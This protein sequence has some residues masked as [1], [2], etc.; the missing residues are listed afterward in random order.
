VL[1]APKESRF[2]DRRLMKIRLLAP[3]VALGFCMVSAR[4][5]FTNGQAATYVLGQ[6]SLTTSDSNPTSLHYWGA[7]DVAI[8]A[9]TGKAFVIDI[10]AS[11]ILRYSNVDTLAMGGAPE[12]VLGQ[13]NLDV[14]S[15]GTSASQLNNPGGLALDSS[16]RLWVA[17][18]GNNRVLRFDNASMKPNG[19]NAD[20]VLGQNDFVNVAP[21]STQS[22][23]SSPAAV[24]VDNTGTLWIADTQNNRVLRFANAATKANGA[25]ADGVLGQPNFTSNAITIPAT[26]SS[27]NQP[28]GLCADSSGHLWVA[29]TNDARVLRFDNA[30]TEADPDGAP[31]DHVLGQPSLIGGSSG[32]SAQL[33]SSPMNIDIDSTGLLA[34]SDKNNKR[35]LL[36]A[37]AA[38]LGDGADATLVLGQTSFNAQGQGG[39][40]ASQIGDP[41]SARFDAAGRLWVV[42]GSARRVLRFDRSRM[43]ENSFQPQILTTRDKRSVTFTITNAGPLPAQFTLSTKVKALGN[44]KVRDRWLLDGANVTRAF[45]FGTVTTRPLSQGDATTLVYKP[46]RLHGGGLGLLRL[47]VRLAAAST[48]YPTLTVAAATRLKQ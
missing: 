47:K 16:G 20:A 34:V 11:R 13:T 36:W 19:A 30:A 1:P 8:D 29:D 27:M 12:A 9:R 24:C 18:S 40:T 22:G 43:L 7:Q 15:P 48:N 3:L 10:Y 26:A 21:A 41:R 23:M 39:L 31:A 35:C 45:R 33:L 14:G 2:R 5:Q 6:S 32:T 38:S 37:N 25:N 17:D 42:D 4:A 28:S 46:A 44:G